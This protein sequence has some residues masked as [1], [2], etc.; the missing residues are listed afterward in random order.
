MS[1]V[2]QISPIQDLRGISLKPISMPASGPARTVASDQAGDGIFGVVPTPWAE[3]RHFYARS[4]ESKRADLEGQDF[5]TFEA[6]DDCICFAVCDGVG[7]SF[8]GHWAA[9]FLGEWLLDWLRHELPMLSEGDAAEKLGRRLAELTSTARAQVRSL[10][11]PDDLSPL[12]L[13]ALEGIRAYGSET[14]FAAGRVELDRNRGRGWVRLFWLGDTQLRVFD[15]TGLP[16]ELGAVWAPRERWSS[17]HGV[18]GVEGVHTW[19]GPSARVGR[20]QAYSDGLSAVSSRLRELVDEPEQLRHEVRGLEASPSSDD[21]SLVDIRLRDLQRPRLR[22]VRRAWFGSYLLAWDPVPDA[23]AYQ[24]ERRSAQDAQV[25]ETVRVESTE[26]RLSG[27]R[28]GTWWY[29]VRAVFDGIE[30]EAGESRCVR[31]L[32]RWPPWRRPSGFDS[33]SAVVAES[34]GMYP[35]DSR[36]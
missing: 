21:M 33:A 32:L 12:M 27:Q 13:E 23:L 28:P 5:L 24:V 31:V 10:E 29:A 35:G 7:Q 14:M 34:P 8:F 1:P 25:P 17:E 22:P 20:I 2:V 3:V 6:G 4:R 16:V 19:T 18:K 15:A 30:G 26:L 9:R 11:L 36:Y